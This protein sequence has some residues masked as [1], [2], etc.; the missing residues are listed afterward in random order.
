MPYILPGDK[1]VTL[2]VALKDAFD[3]MAIAPEDVVPEWETTDPGVLSLEAA[4]D[5]MSATA[6]PAG[7]GTCQV[8]ARIDETTAGTF[9]IEVVAGAPTTLEISAAAAEPIAAGRRL[10]L[11]QAPPEPAPL[12][13]PEEP[14]QGR[15]ARRAKRGA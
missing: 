8:T 10:V 9:E 12:N 14:V 6:Y 1:Q 5:G 13:E 3:A 2:F 15:R 7:V 4:P 11:E